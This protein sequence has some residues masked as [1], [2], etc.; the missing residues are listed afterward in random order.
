ML[1][2]TDFFAGQEH[3]RKNSGSISSRCD[4]GCGKIRQTRRAAIS[5]HFNVLGRL[6]IEPLLAARPKPLKF[7]EIAAEYIEL[8]GPEPKQASDIEPT[9]FLR[10]GLCLIVKPA[11]CRAGHQAPLRREN[12]HRTPA[13]RSDWSVPP[14][15]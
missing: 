15:T 8:M 7:R 12:P 10:I 3:L 5:L 9:R 4:A 2:L 6:Q 14:L 1:S 13:S 11:M